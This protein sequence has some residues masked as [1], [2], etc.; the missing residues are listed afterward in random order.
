MSFAGKEI[1]QEGEGLAAEFLKRQG[2]AILQRNFGCKQ[3]E[4]DIVAQDGE[5]LVFVEVKAFYKASWA[6]GPAVNVTP[7]K[8]KQIIRA[9]RVYL[10]KL[11]K[12]AYS[13]FDVVVVWPGSPKP[14]EHL[15]GAFGL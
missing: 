14:V 9:A 7:A 8:Q 2:Y 6:E 4:I 5:T 15:V 13:R 10:A 1:G 11:G 12:E 3:G